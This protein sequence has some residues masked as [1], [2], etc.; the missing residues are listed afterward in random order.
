MSINFTQH[1]EGVQF[2]CSTPFSNSNLSNPSGCVEERIVFISYCEIPKDIVFS[3][4]YSRYRPKV[5]FTK[6]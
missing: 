3:R 5:R 6:R 1:G 4:N 2:F